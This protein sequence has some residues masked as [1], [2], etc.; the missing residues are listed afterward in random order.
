MRD[1]PGVGVLAADAGDVRPVALGAPLERVVVH[2]FGRERIVAVALHLVAQRADHL[3]VAKVA[4]FA[5]IDV[6]A[7]EFERRVGPHALH[8]FDGALQIEER[9]DLDQAAD[10]DHDENAE[11][12]EDRILL[13]DVVPGEKR[14]AV[15]RLRGAAHALS[16][17]SAG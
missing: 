4:A 10:R 3:A 14:P 12:E 2:A 15:V 8:G 13:Q 1:V 9:H 7:G 5:H 17:H 11:D 6:A 16:P